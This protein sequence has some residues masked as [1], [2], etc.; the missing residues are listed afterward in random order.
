MLGIVGRQ[1]ALLKKELGSFLVHA[2][3]EPRQS[4]IFQPKSASCLFGSSR[5]S[6]Q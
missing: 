3:K 1:T 4:A 5:W 2:L 6:L